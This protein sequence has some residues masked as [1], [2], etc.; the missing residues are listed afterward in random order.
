M[1]VN[2]FN[3]VPMRYSVV[4]NNLMPEINVVF[5]I[6]DSASKGYLIDNMAQFTV[7]WTDDCT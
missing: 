1:G 7:A 2:P 3:P 4:V 5:V 6:G